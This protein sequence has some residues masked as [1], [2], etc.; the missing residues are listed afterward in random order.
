MSS[1]VFTFYVVRVQMFSLCVLFRVSTYLPSDA[2][3]DWQI[4]IFI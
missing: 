4:I 3:L 2:L 1:D